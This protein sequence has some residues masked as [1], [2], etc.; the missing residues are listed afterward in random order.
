LGNVHLDPR[1]G[2]LFVDFEEGS[3]LQVTGEAEL[4]WGGPNAAGSGTGLSVLVRVRGAL[5][6]EGATPRR[7]R[8]SGY[9]PHNPES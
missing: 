3:V 2:L 4:R 5:L 1:V 9:S 6:T 8:L 7:W